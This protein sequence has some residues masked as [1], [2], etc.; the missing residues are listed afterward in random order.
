MRR[1]EA[2]S[3][4]FLGFLLLALLTI[5]LVF[6][7]LPLSF[8]MVECTHNVPLLHAGIL[9]IQ[10][11]YH[12]RRQ[13]PPHVVRWERCKGCWKESD[14]IMILTDGFMYVVLGH[15]II[16]IYTYIQAKRVQQPQPG[17]RRQ[18]IFFFF[19]TSLNF[20]FELLKI[21]YGPINSLN[22]SDHLTSFEIYIFGI[23][24]SKSRHS[25]NGKCLI[26]VTC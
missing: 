12:L 14:V 7:T 2:C 17:K 10:N 5:C 3:L 22:W 13:V 16:Y 18:T 24:S 23:S 9:N 20:L 19:T 21:R 15:I 4:A 6:F 25:I 26:F 1:L 8:Q 11:R